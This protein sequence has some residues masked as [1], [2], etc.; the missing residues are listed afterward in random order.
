MS[1]GEAEVLNSSTVVRKL[2]RLDNFAPESLFL[3][4]KSKQSVRGRTF[5]EIF[6]LPF[7]EFQQSIHSQCDHDMIEKMKETALRMSKNASKV[8]KLFGSAD[9]HVP[10]GRLQR[11]FYPQSTFRRIWD[12]VI[13]AGCIFYT[14]S[15]PLQVMRYLDGADF[16]DHLATFVVSYFWDLCFVLDLY[17]KFNHFMFLDEGLVVFDRHCIRQQFVQ[18]HNIVLNFVASVPIDL[19]GLINPQWCFLLRLT[20]LLKLSQTVESFGYLERVLTDSKLDKGL[21]IL[22]ISQ[23][24]Y[25]LVV[26][27]HW[28]GCMWHSCANISLKLGHD[29]NWLKQD[30]EDPALSI[31][32]DD[33][34]GFGAYLRSVYWAIV[35]TSTV[36][37][38]DIIP[39]NIVE[40][41]FATV[42]ILFG[43]L[44]LPAIVGKNTRVYKFVLFLQ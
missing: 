18:E 36:G 22:K 34:N 44:V 11:N 19:V 14:F 28:I 13:L 23:L 27:C 43:G 8:N 16:R 15:V 17:L 4:N 37:Y 3:K 10:T 32:H 24:N 33:L 1:R 2:R 40:T 6:L 25:A 31:D 35:S 7:N 21:I 9:D 39:M 26:T 30:E 38:G 5:C 41:T 42:I 12:F 29:T 20:K